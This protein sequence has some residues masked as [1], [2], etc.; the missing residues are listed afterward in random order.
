VYRDTGLRELP[1]F[2]G[3]LPIDVGLLYGRNESLEEKGG[4][5]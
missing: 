3:R 4:I 2:R 5:K 1:R